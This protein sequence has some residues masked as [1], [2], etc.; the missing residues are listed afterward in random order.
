[1]E[2]VQT[3]KK[4]EKSEYIE[5]KTE[6]LEKIQVNANNDI[7]PPKDKKKK[8]KKKTKIED[9][10]PEDNADDKNHKEGLITN[11]PPNLDDE[12]Q[13]C[14]NQIKMGIKYNNLD[15]DQSIILIR[16]LSIFSYRNLSMYNALYKNYKKILD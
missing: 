8:K 6:S 15:K 3:D 12:I 2:Q 9:E 10:L 1:M 14:V 13:W 7:D 16:I 11:D 5:E 4:K